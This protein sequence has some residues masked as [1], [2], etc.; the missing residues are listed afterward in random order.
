MK[1]F[2][3]ITL[4]LEKE[5]LTYPGDPK[6]WIQRK[7]FT[8]PENPESYNTSLVRLFSHGGTHLDPPLH[9]KH[10]GQSVDQIDLQV[11]IGPARVVEFD[12]TCM[13]ISVRDL[14]TMGLESVERLLLKTSNSKL[15]P[16]TVTT[17]YVHLTESGARYLREQTRIRL[18]GIDYISIE[19]EDP[20]GFPVHRELLTKEP[21][22]YILEGINL[23]G[24]TPGDYELICLPLRLT[25]GDGGP[26]R[27]VLAI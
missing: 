14:Q 2:I 4:A 5:M 12:D 10:D 19:T 1:E 9:F 24:V 8:H 20:P 21:P 18:V 11:L 26:A 22:I 3:D 17:N 7:S 13:E 15:L 27:A 16:H 6:F 23:A 25:G